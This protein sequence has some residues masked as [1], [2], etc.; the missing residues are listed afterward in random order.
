MSETKEKNKTKQVSPKNKSSYKIISL[1]FILIVIFSISFF[2]LEKKDKNNKKYMEQ[3]IIQ[4]ENTVA[5]IDSS[6]N[7]NNKNLLNMKKKLDEYKSENDVLSDLVSQPIKEQFTIN[8]DYALLEIEHLLTIANHNLLLGGDYQKI[9]SIIEIAKSRLDGI[10]IEKAKIIQQELMK[11]INI[12]KSYNIAD[13]T[14]IL[15]LLS[16]LSNRIES[17][18]LKKVIIKENNNVTSE[19]NEKRIEEKKFLDYVLAELK[20]LVLITYDKNLNGRVFSPNNINSIIKYEILNAKLSL[21]NRSKK[22]L[23]ESIYNIKNTLSSHYDL[24]DPELIDILEKLSRISGLELHIPGIDIT[25]SLE[26]VRALIRIQ[27]QL[28]DKKS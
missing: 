6:I 1:F 9:L 15:I 28:S 17:F 2:F 12:I 14:E 3:K 25:S 16:N 13:S 4:I 20:N 21:L 26:S 24:T 22:D 5:N 19:D 10:D 23:D 18:S 27:S 8:V 11:Q 7:K